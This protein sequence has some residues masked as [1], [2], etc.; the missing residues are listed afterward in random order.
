[1]KLHRF[2]GSFDFAQKQIEIT[3]VDVVHQLT[4]VLRV[5]PGDK[6][7]LCDGNNNDA[8]AAV[9]QINNRSLLVDVVNTYKNTNEPVRDVS[10]YCA[11]LKRNNFE[12]VI[13]KA[14]EVGVKMII[15]L[16][17][18]RT[19]RQK[20]NINR[21][22]TIAKEAAEQSGRGVI[23]SIVEPTRFDSLVVEKNK[24]LLRL[25]YHTQEYIDT[26][27]KSDLSDINIFIGPEGGWD[28]SEVDLA[29]KFNFQFA[30]LGKLTLRAET[31]AIVA[32]YFAIHI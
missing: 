26:P 27:K 16:I 29:K 18:K 10:L 28:T 1:M 22:K 17:T 25:F 8:L 31:A 19:I 20:V 15:P 32:S 21:L 7:I 2:I 30:T 12:L 24:S 4:K 9:T 13:Q 6:I 11:V 14:T 3:D 5:N 23:P